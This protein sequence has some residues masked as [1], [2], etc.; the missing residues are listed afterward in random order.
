VGTPTS[1]HVFCSFVPHFGNNAPTSDIGKLDTL[2]KFFEKCAAFRA[3]G[4]QI[5]V[6]AALSTVL[7]GCQQTDTALPAT[8]AAEPANFACG[9][10]GFLRTELLGAVNA[11]LYWPRDALS[12][13]GMPRPG[14]A[15]VRLRFAGTYDE[16]P[17]TLII[18]LPQLER[19]ATAKELDTRITLIPEGT[20]LFFSNASASH[21]LT[22]ITS[23]EALDASSDHVAIAGTIYCVMPLVQVNDRPSVSIPKLEFRGLLDWNAS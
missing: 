11:E 2:Q 3:A 17:I 8:V 13:E 5:L 6:A 1:R 9:E 4:Y 19:G 7:F 16:Q 18:A 10:N 12:C 14:G 20:G 22:E 23:L 15:G 21:C